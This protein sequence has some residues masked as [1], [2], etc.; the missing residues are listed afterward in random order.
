MVDLVKSLKKGILGKRNPKSDNTHGFLSARGIITSYRIVTMTTYFGNAPHNTTK[1]S[2]VVSTPHAK[3]EKTSSSDDF[4]ARKQ[5]SSLMLMEDWQFLTHHPMKAARLNLNAHVSPNYGIS[6]PIG[7]ISEGIQSLE[8][9]WGL[10]L[11]FVDQQKPLKAL[12]DNGIWGASKHFSD[13][14]LDTRVLKWTHENKNVF[15]YVNCFYIRAG[16]RACPLVALFVGHIG[17]LPWFLRFWHQNLTT[18]C[19]WL[20]F[21]V[22]VVEYFGMFCNRWLFRVSDLFQKLQI[23]LPL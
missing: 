18:G 21:L 2:I 13:R 6:V 10:A 5:Y 4:L 14:F 16:L 15:V 19:A 20:T 7:T 23:K 22:F 17:S 8:F 12:V 3:V 11:V 1:A 9:F